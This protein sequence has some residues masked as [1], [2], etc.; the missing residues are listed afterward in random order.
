M[1]EW[2]IKGFEDGLWEDFRE[3]KK[4]KEGCDCDEGCEICLRDGEKEGA[5]KGRYWGENSWLPLEGVVKLF[6]DYKR[7]M[8][9]VEKRKPFEGDMVC[10]EHMD[11][12]F[13]GFKKTYLEAGIKLTRLPERW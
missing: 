12:W 1:V 11:A 9:S 5:I 8:N 3:D 4:Y 2:N 10:W 7:F 6:E 13:K